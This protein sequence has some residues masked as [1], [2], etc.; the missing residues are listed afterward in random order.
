M[1][2]EIIIMQELDF[3]ETV[4]HLHS[5]IDWNKLKIAEEKAFQELKMSYPDFIKTC[6][7][8]EE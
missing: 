8:L 1:K 6:N 4:N 3:K 5:M 2:E 7:L